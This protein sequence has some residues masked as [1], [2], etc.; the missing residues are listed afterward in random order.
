MLVS[1]KKQVR[2]QVWTLF[3]GYAPITTA[4]RSSNRK[5]TNT[6]AGWIKAAMA[7]NTPDALPIIRVDMPRTTSSGFSKFN[8]FD[9]EDDDFIANGGTGSIDW[10]FVVRVTLFSEVKKVDEQDQLID[11]AQMAILLAGPKLGLEFVVTTGQITTQQQEVVDNGIRKL[12]TYIDIPFNAQ[13]DY[14]ELRQLA[15]AP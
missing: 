7:F 10:K 1:F 13:F 11:D 12:R 6:E 5:R 9:A 15:I 2:D 4:I 3:E 14:Q 8:T